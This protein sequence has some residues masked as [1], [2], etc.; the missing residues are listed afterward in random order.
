[1]KP[2]SFADVAALVALYRPGPM[3]ANMHNDYVD[4]K[5][6]RKPITYAHPD[7]EDLLADTYGLMIYQEAVMRVAQRIAGYSLAE[8]DLLRKAM[9]K[10]SR[11][12][13]ATERAKF[14][15]AAERTGYGTALGTTL[16][17]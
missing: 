17:D 2:T 10:K 12:V 3:A 15:A 4:R 9:G 11:E 7:L 6:G 14:V 5:N 8:A 16:F 13:I 1:M